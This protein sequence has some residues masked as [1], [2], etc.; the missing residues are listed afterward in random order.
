[1]L[2]ATLASLPD[3]W[4]KDNDEDTGDVPSNHPWWVSPDIWVRHQD[5]Y[6]LVHQNPIVSENNTVY[7][8]LRNRGNRT[9]SGEVQVFWDRSRIGWP[10]IVGQPNVGTIPFEDLAPG[11]VRIV[12]LQWEPQEVGHHGLHTV[13]QAEGDPADWS[14]PCSP[15]LPR[16]DNNVSWHNVIVYMHPLPGAQRVKSVEEAVVDLVNVY[17]WPK[18]ADLIVERGTFPVAG[19]ISLRLD[20]ELFDRWW[21][22]GWYEG[23]Q[24][25]AA[26]RVITVTSAVSATIGS[27]PL[28]PREEV[29]AT[30]TFDA[31]GEG[32]F[33]VQISERID[34][35]IVGGISY[36]WLD[37]DDTP[38]AVEAT[39]PLSEAV[40][41]ALDAPIIVTFTEQIGPLSL[42]LALEPNPGDR[43]LTWNEGGT[44]VTATYSGFEPATTCTA[45][46]RA[47][48]A[49]AN[50]MEKS[51]AWTFTV[52]DR[53]RIY[54]PL[55][56]R[57]R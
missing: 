3:V 22:Y 8:R 54:L 2:T 50:V 24:V 27:L 11:E 49:F 16:W 39:S 23:V 36:Q 9:T 57:N 1:L 15:H 55:V 38:P 32:A 10:C 47:G 34:G 19:T 25:D 5:D 37:D 7:V 51:Y 42:V 46:V 12:S 45:T 33:E 52:K 53:Y 29:T 26:T 43:Y 40:E 18:G 17:D 48:D 28:E 6:G 20:E 56:L 31:P 21:G 13:I 4:T 30:L 14:A 44:V 35:L 41:V